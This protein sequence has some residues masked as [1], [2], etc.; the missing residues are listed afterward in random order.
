M[1]NS[2]RQIDLTAVNGCENFEA[3]QIQYDEN[4]LFVRVGA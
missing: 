1:F 3:N 4:S 2:E